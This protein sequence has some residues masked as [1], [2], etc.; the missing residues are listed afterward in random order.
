QPALAFEPVSTAGSA[1]VVDTPGG[2]A[3]LGATLRAAH[4]V[5]VFALWDG[6]ARRPRLA[7]LGLAAGGDGGGGPWYVPVGHQGG[8]AVLDQS[9]VTSELAPVFGSKELLG[10]D[11]KEADLVLRAT[12][13]AP[14]GWAHSSFLAA[15]LLGAGS[16]D[17]RLED[18]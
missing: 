15:Y 17:P 4:D 13:T 10:H 1:F 5:A 6:P 18:L 3:D 2:I 12:G 14:L 16:R 9:A 7:G 11:A 8:E